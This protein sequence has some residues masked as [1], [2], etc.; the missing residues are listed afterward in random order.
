MT[1]DP[2]IKVCQLWHS[3]PTFHVSQ[4]IRQQWAESVQDCQTWNLS[5]RQV[6]KNIYDFKMTFAKH[7]KVRMFLL[8]VLKLY[9][10]YFLKLKTLSTFLSFRVFDSDMFDLQRKPWTLT[11]S[12]LIQH[13][14]FSF[15]F[16]S[17]FF[18]FFFLWLWRW[19][20]G[21]RESLQTPRTHVREKLGILREKT[22]FY[23]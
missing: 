20:P 13:Y 14:H 22:L 15:S 18:F 17:F 23:W 5:L 21:E 4:P 2:V 1:F 3:C 8:F 16:S 11:S 9:F 10:L 6:G 7:K 12:D 19:S